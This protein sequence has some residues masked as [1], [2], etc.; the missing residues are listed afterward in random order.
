MAE[1]RW[2]PSADRHGVPHDQ[3]IYAMVNPL[4]YEPEFD[5]PRVP[6]GVRPDL[7]IG[8]VGPGLG[9]TLLEIMTNRY[10]GVLVIFHVMIARKKHL[11]RMEEN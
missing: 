7:Y 9:V 11:I 5:E 8:P 6:G 10:P 2:A 3:A 1:I 4:Y